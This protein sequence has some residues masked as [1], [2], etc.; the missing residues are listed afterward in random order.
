MAV[1]KANIDLAKIGVP[2]LYVGGGI[3]GYMLVIKPIFNALGIT[4]SAE[5]QA[6]DVA[7]TY[8]VWG[9]SFYK[10][11]PANQLLLDDSTAATYASI[12]QQYP[13]LLYDNY[14]GVLGVFQALRTKSQVSQLC[15][16]FQKKY[17]RSLYAYLLD[18][19]GILP[20]DGLSGDH[21]TQIN[22]IVNSLPNYTV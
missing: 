3:L 10:N 18:G 12:I 4:K 8:P 22:K 11:G 17:N 13:G 9:A 14:A 20:W 15:D 2:L 6:I 19:G 21:L 7:A 1:K 16:V 5:Q